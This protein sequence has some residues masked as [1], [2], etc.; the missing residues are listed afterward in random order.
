MIKDVAE[1]LLESVQK[2]GLAFEIPP[3]QAQ[4]SQASGAATRVAFESDIAHNFPPARRDRLGYA[5]YS[6]EFRADADRTKAD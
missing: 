2:K 1:L 5:E 4:A 3:I 6:G